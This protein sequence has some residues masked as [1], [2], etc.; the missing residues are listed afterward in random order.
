M[1]LDAAVVTDEAE[2]AKAIHEEADTG[3]RRADH[4]RQGLLRNVGNEI[5]LVLLAFQTPPSTVESVARRLS[6]L[7]KS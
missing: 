4:L 6:L 2:R 1:Y 3:P 7:L 5:P